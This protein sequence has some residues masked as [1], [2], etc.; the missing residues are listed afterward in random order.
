[1]DEFCRVG[2]GC[3]G[4]EEATS[5]RPPMEV[6]EVD[7]GIHARAVVIGDDRAKGNHAA[8][9]DVFVDVGV[10]GDF[11]EPPDRIGVGIG[12]AEEELVVFDAA[13][14]E[15]FGNP[16]FQ[17]FFKINVRHFAV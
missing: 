8:V 4:F 12:M 6:V 2:G 11:V 16:F 17:P 7:V 10:G 14:G 13:G 1:M 15:I 3:F 9:G 5:E